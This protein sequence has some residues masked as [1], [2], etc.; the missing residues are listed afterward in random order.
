MAK[1]NATTKEKERLYLYI[2]AKIC[3][4]ICAIFESLL[5]IERIVSKTLSGTGQKQ[6]NELSS[7]KD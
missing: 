3:L 1:F 2:K 6:I 7:L 5:P 4:F